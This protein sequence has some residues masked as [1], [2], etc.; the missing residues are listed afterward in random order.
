M[1]VA[2]VRI[3]VPLFATAGLLASGIARAG[4]HQPPAPPAALQSLAKL[5]GTWQGSAKVSDK[6][7]D[8]TVPVTFVY[9]AT[10]GGSAIVEHLFPGTPHEM[11]SVYTA[12]G[13]GVA[14]T[15]DGAAAAAPAASAVSASR[16]LRSL[17]MLSR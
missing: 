16:F 7:G 17:S 15:I 5:A 3:A 13:D 12:E 11:M 1:H 4:D 8:K 2:S 14:R 10:A 6:T 9:E